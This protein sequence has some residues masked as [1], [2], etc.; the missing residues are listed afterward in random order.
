MKLHSFLMTSALVMSVI[1]ST[2]TVKAMTAE[3]KDAYTDVLM[4]SYLE[5]FAEALNMAQMTHN[6]SYPLST[7]EVDD[8]CVALMDGKMIAG[9]VGRALSQTF[10]DNAQGLDNLVQG[11]SV[12]AKYCP[13]YSKMS[14][15]EK[16]IVWV[17]ILTAMAHFESNCTRTASAKGPNGTAY[18]YFQL[19]RGHEENY[20][21]GSF[22]Q[23]GDAAKPLAA[24]KCTL[25]MLEKQFENR[26]GEL[27]SNKS[28]WDVLRPTG[29]SKKWA[30]I[31]KA[32]MRS[33]LCNP[34]TI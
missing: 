9:D 29:S 10:L 8:K 31:K 6:M 21:G 1:T 20:G 16:S 23:K 2:V 33:T 17:F 24:S 32:L 28:Y 11:G 15:K 4:P 5:E 27:F 19:H 14:S 25:G 13:Q 3:E 26:E 30:V 12:R 22:C 18:G 34:R 7:A